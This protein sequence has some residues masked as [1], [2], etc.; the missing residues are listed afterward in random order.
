MIDPWIWI[1]VGAAAA[2][3]VRFFLQRALRV[4]ALSSVGATFARF[5]YSAP[6]VALLAVGILVARAQP[7]PAM[8]PAFWVYATAGGIAQIVA[9]VC[10]VTLFARRNFAVGVTLSKTEVL[11][12]ALVGFAVLGDG[13]GPVALAAMALGIAGVILLSDVPDLSG[14]WY[15]RLFNASAGLGLAAGALFAVS[16]VGYRGA[17]LALGSGDALS[18]AVVTLA[19]VTAGQS[20]ASGVWLAW[21]EPGQVGRVASA[22][23][24]AAPM[25]LASLAGSLGWFTAFAMQPVA[26]VKAV[27]QVEV[28]FVLFAS[29]CLLSERITAREWCGLVALT[30]SVLWLVL[31]R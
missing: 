24:L 6:L 8:P 25:G 3:A 22:W 26:Y 23:R 13:I 29:V 4:A 17:T 7:L 19:V 15:R 5:A 28:A 2:Q 14:A 1:S 12:S 18:R 27:G 20:V 10:V 31:I 16:A 11:F 21:R 9:T 30:A